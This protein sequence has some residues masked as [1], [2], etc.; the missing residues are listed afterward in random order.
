MQVLKNVSL[1]TCKYASMQIYKYKRNQIN[2]AFCR[3]LSIKVCKY[4]SMGVCKNARAFSQEKSK[5]GQA[6]LGLNR[7]KLSKIRAKS[8]ENRDKITILINLTKSTSHQTLNIGKIRAKSGQ[9]RGK[10]RAKSGQIGPKW[11]I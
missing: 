5:S 6:I 3:F 1:Q 8:G 2:Y 11:Y 7:G 4:T 10:I 9:N